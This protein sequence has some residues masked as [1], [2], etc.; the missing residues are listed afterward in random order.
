MHRLNLTKNVILIIYSCLARTRSGAV[1]ADREKLYIILYRH[2]FARQSFRNL[3]RMY[4]STVF[5]YQLDMSGSGRFVLP[6]PRVRIKSEAQNC[7][8]LCMVRI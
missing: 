4:F 1:W 6:Y 5:E 2:S 3:V 7:K 8:Q